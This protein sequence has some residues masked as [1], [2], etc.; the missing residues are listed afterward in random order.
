MF[1]DIA[2]KV[3]ILSKSLQ[4]L[5]VILDVFDSEVKHSDLEIP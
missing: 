2:D 5:V 4:T 1:A 3:T